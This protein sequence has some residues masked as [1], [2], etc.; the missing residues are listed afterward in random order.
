[1]DS[2]IHFFIHSINILIINKHLPLGQGRFQGATMSFNPAWNIILKIEKN[3]KVKI[4]SIQLYS[5]LI[6]D[7]SQVHNKLTQYAI[8]ESS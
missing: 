5:P 3:L 6:R 1:M 2:F 8:S 7:T 4:V